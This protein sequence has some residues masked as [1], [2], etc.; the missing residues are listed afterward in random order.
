MLEG[1]VSFSS[2]QFRSFDRYFTFQVINVFL[3]TTIAGSVIDCVKDIYTDPSSAFAL[4][5]TSLP[6][7]GGYFTNYLIMKAFIGLGMEIMRLPAIFAAVLKAVFTSNVTPRD[8]NAQPLFGS[9]RAMHN[10]GWF[11]FSK[12]YAQD[13]LLVVLCAT[14]ACI[15]PLILAAGLCYFGGASYVYKHQ[16]LYVYEPIYETGGRW[17]P[18]TA[19][20][21]VV[22]LLFAQAT[23]VG[24]M[25]LKETYTEIYFLALIIVM[26]SSYY[27][28]AASTYEP[29]AAQLPFDMA[30]SMDLDQESFSD[31]LVGAGDYIQPS[32]RANLV[33]PI[34]EFPLSKPGDPMGL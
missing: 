21:F 25:I 8:R 2:N 31:E 16:M 24:M 7:M 9:I 29:L 12:I 14:Y 33:I 19:R 34:V 30:T 17:W 6:K 27:W 10:P 18:K 22:A 28:L 11:P 32:L 20:C 23:M 13:L 5:G 3:V 4:L 1:C 15:A 26:T